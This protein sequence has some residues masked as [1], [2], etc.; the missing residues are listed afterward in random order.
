MTI[1]TEPIGS[2]PRPLALIQGMKAFA[3]GQLEEGELHRLQHE[4]LSDTI[5]RFEATGSPVITDGGQTKPSFATY[6][7]AGMKDLD[8]AGVIIPFANGL[9]PRIETPE[10]IRETILEAAS[11]IPVTQLGTTDDC[12]SSSFAD[13]VPTSRDIAFT[14]IKARID[15]TR[16][17]EVALNS[18]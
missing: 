10:E 9:N 5:K 4:A 11:V 6:P 15:G 1:K 8:P 17:A 18:N 16:L 12:G 14:K 3:Q 7:L 13:D 2:I